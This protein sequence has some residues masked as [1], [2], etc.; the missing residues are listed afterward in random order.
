VTSTTHNARNV[1]KF[2]T[3]AEKPVETFWLD[4][5]PLTQ[6]RFDVPA[7]QYRACIPVYD[8]DSGELV[9]FLP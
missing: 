9:E 1:G 8:R 3:A 2:V 7:P 5:D 4:R 6:E